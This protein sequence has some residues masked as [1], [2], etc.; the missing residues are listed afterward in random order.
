MRQSQREAHFKSGSP[1]LSSE[2]LTF[3]EGDDEITARFRNETIQRNRKRNLI[4]GIIFV[5]LIL[6]I[7]LSLVI[8]ANS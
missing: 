7:V 1:E 2:Q 4:R 3:N 6:S 8:L 5:S